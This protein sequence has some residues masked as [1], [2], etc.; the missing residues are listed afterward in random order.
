MVMKNRNIDINNITVG[1]TIFSHDLKRVILNKR[2]SGCLYPDTYGI[3][4]GKVRVGETLLSAIR[5][6]LYEENHLIVDR[7]SYVKCYDHHGIYLFLYSAIIEDSSDSFILLDDIR[8]LKLAPNIADAISES[9]NFFENCG[10]LDINLVELIN[11]IEKGVADN[12][13]KINGQV[14]WDHFLCMRRIGI[15]GT[16]VGL[17]IINKTTS[18]NDLKDSIYKT[19]TQMQLDNGGWGVRSTNNVYAVTESTCNCLSAIYDFKHCF[20]DSIN[21]AIEW[22]KSNRLDDGLWGYNKDCVHGRITTTCL[23]LETLLKLKIEFQLEDIVSSIL[24]CQN[25]DGGWG[26][27]KGEP[28]NI[29]ATSCVVSTLILCKS[30]NDSSIIRAVAWIETKLKNEVVDQSEIGYIGD[31]R[32]EYKHSTRIYVLKALIRQKGI[33]NISPEFLFKS[34]LEIIDSRRVCGFWEHSLTP[35]YFPIWHTNNILGLL[36]VF[37]DDA[38]ILNFSYVQSKYETYRFELDCLKFLENRQQTVEQESIIYY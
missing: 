17:N 29:T 13:Q 6:E 38:S 33:E 10:Q 12:V 3:P 27:L 23:V 5:R 25:I 34:I 15:T 1:V 24:N 26:F 2:D 21:R 20:N 28:S 8:E 32:F 16:A 36:R 4:G 31:K 19:L 14:G 35:G 11:D 37:I 9:I 30:K 7:M 22:I 18:Y